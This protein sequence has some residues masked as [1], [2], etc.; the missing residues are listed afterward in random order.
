VI[1]PHLRGAEEWAHLSAASS[2][3][4]NCTD[5]CPVKIDLHHHLLQNRRDAVQQ[6]FDGP[7]QRLAFRAW[8]WAMESP[9]RYAVAGRL[10]RLG[11]RL[12]LAGKL[13]QPWTAGRELPAVPAQSFRDWWRKHEPGA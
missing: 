12:G 13:A 4:G 5:V 8:L 11:I 9:S 3:C 1:T 2:L 6:R 7:W 10:A